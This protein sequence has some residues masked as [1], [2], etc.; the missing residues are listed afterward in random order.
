MAEGKRVR[1]DHRGS[2]LSRF[3][4][5]A[6]AI[7]HDLGTGGVALEVEQQ[8]LT[9]GHGPEAQDQFW[10]SPF[11]EG[12]DAQKGIVAGNNMALIVLTTAELREWIGQNGIAESL[13][14]F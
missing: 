3:L 5:A 12:F 9:G 13:C 11:K 6:I 8:R 7:D 1:M 10:L 4:P 2:Q 14:Q